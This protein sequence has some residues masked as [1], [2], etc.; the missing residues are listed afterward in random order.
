MEAKQVRPPPRRRDQQ[1]ADLTKTT[2]PTCRPHERRRSKT[3]KPKV[4][5]ADEEGGPCD[6]WRL[7][8]RPRSSKA[9]ISTTPTQPSSAGRANSRQATRRW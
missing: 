9:N 4:R 1:K 6:S 3:T 2:R 8:A 5:K 7:L